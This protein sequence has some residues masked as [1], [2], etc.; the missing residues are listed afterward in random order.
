MTY[1]RRAGREAGLAVQVA[2]IPREAEETDPAED[3]LYGDARGDELP[4]ELRNTRRPSAQD[5]RS[6]E[7]MEREAR[8]ATASPGALPK[9]SA[10]R[11]FTDPESRIMRSRTEGWVQAYNAGAGVDET[12]QIIVATTPSADPTES[13][14][15]PALVD[16]VQAGRRPKRVLAHAGLRG[17]RQHRRPREPR[18][19]WL[20]RDRTREPRPRKL[21]IAPGPHPRI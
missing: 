1:G 4:P 11:N 3:K 19:R 10:Q 8:E 13:R 6:R 20:H 12:A 21:A 2:G 14:S 16:G 9:P 15:L 5:P 18:H 17:Q 7:A